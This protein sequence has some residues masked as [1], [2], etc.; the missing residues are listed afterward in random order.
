MA[1]AAPVWP[2]SWRATASRGRTA[3][4][5]SQSSPWKDPVGFSARIRNCLE[6]PGTAWI[7]RLRPTENP[8]N[9]KA[10]QSHDSH[11]SHGL[12]A[13]HRKEGM[14]G[15]R[16]VHVRQSERP[17]WSAL[18]ITSHGW[19]QDNK[20]RRVVGSVRKLEWIWKKNKSNYW[21]LTYS[22]IFIHIHPYSSYSVFPLFFRGP[23]P[24]SLPWPGGPGPEVLPSCGTRSW[25]V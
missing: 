5:T 14:P 4:P 24:G 13:S 8:K 6:L 20:H 3:W 12:T 16:G 23:G 11:G 10:A 17:H 21:P 9:Q 7:W 18:C 15:V 22:S 19:P 2:F 25:P 1:I